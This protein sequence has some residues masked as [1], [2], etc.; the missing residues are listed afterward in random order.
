MLFLH[1]IVHLHSNIIKNI[2]CHKTFTI[3]DQCDMITGG[4]GGGGVRDTGSGGGNDVCPLM[5]Q[6][7]R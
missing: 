2:I 7:G 6:D 3:A 5:V 4:G 1:F